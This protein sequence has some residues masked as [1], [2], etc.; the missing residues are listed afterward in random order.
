MK[1]LFLSHHPHEIHLQ[2]VKSLG[3][4]IQI[5]HLEWLV[6]LTKKISFVWYFY[7]LFSFLYSLFIKVKEDILLVD[8]G[9]S[10]YIGVF[11]KIRYPNLKIILFDDDLFFYKINEKSLINLPSVFYNKIDAVISVS[12]QN[13]ERILRYIKVP[14]YSFSPYPRSLKKIKEIRR[15]DGLYLGRLDPDK[16][17]KRIIKFGLQC[18]FFEKFIIVGNG[19]FK[20][21]TKKLSLVNKK[22][23]YNKPTKEVEKFYSRCKFL[24]H[25]PDYD[26]HPFTTMEAALCDCFPIISKGVGTNYLFDDLFIVNDPNNFEEINEKIKYILENEN[27]AKRLLKDSI[28]RFSTKDKTIKDFHNK[29][30]K[31][32]NEIRK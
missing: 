29:F 25:I 4:R 3:T 28:K 21:Y 32:I 5:L 9:T 18:P 6:N 23:I 2:I 17:I 20:S 30:Y 27:E 13:K 24:I 1:I 14:A 31:L 10:L 22:L 7:F 19:I 16:D 26:P 12:E 8:G 15:N 11:L